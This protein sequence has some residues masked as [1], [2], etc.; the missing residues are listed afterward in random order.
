MSGSYSEE[1]SLLKKLLRTEAFRFVIIRY[2]HYSSV[3]KIKTDLKTAYPNRPTVDLDAESTDFQKVIQSY[4]DLQI[5]ILF[6]ENFEILLKTAKNSLGEETPWMKIENERRRGITS[7]LNLR[8]DKLAKIPN[9]L[10]IFIAASSEEL[11]MPSLLEKMPDLMSFRSLFLDLEIDKSDL[12][13]DNSPLEKQ[14]TTSTIGNQPMISQSQ[15]NKNKKEIRRLEKALAA[16]SE[17]DSLRLTIYPQLTRLLSENGMYDRAIVYFNE[18]LEVASDEE[19]GEIIFDKGKSFMQTGNLPIALRT[20]ESALSYFKKYDE[21]EWVAHSFQYIGDIHAKLGE[22]DKAYEVYQKYNQIEENLV[23]QF[24]EKLSYKNNLSISYQRLGSIYYIKG[25]LRKALNFFKKFH[26]LNKS[27]NFN[28]PKN[29]NYKNNLAFSHERLSSIYDKMGDSNKSLSELEKG[30]KLSEELY[31]TNPKDI[32]YKNNLSIFY[33]Q[34]G[35]IHN[36]LGNIKKGLKLLEEAFQLKKELHLS[37]P[38][39]VSFKNGLAVSYWQLGSFYR[40]NENNL[41]KAKSYFEKSHKLLK[42]LSEAHP[43]HVEFQE[44]FKEIKT[45]LENL[46]NA[47]PPTT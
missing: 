18:W 17:D 4:L 36:K 21:S 14:L 6:I 3:R 7:G 30:F 5:G 22:I 26:E 11:F 39:N 12:V 46:K 38:Q 29:I 13:K 1:F 15:I 16:A 27:L 23:Q 31:L 9:A 34:L 32:N 35:E 2:N 43:Y 10:I 41:T 28:Y 8:R 20:F 24:P 33:E 25:I 19:R 44:N 47:K 37:H 40:D 42:E 45:D